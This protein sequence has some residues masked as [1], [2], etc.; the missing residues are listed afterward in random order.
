VSPPL[1]VLSSPPPAASKWPI[2]LVVVLSV[3]FALAFVAASWLA[4]SR[5][6]H[7]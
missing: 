5:M 1:S 6:R 4:I 3:V 2:V 7:G